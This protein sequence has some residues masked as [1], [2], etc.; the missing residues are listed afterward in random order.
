MKELKMIISENC[1]ELV[2]A[3]EGF[4]GEAYKC[5]AGVWTICYE[6]N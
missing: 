4:R 2:K 5:P 1:V 6:K 3:F